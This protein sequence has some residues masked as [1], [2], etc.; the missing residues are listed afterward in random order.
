MLVSQLCLTLCNPMDCSLPGSADH[1]DSLGYKP[2][3]DLP[4]PGME[5]RS[6]AMQ[7]DSLPRDAQFIIPFIF[8]VLYSNFS[9]RKIFPKQKVPVYPSQ[10]LILY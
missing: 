1:R 7:V 4:N 8:L 2:P 10:N 9:H 5:P 6:P 3:G